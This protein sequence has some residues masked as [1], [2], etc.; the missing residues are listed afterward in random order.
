MMLLESM[1]DTLLKSTCRRVRKSREDLLKNVK[2][3][4]KARCHKLIQTTKMLKAL[5]QMLPMILNDFLFKIQ[6]TS[7]MTN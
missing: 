2:F 4:Q 5:K 1:G 6:K 7:E 3:V